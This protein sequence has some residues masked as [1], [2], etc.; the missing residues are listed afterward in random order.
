VIK[1][2]HYSKLAV[3][4][5]ISLTHLRNFNWRFI[6]LFAREVGDKSS[7][8]EKLSA[9][10]KCGLMSRYPEGINNILPSPS[11]TAILL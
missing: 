11:N 6:Y 1:S 9:V 10:M 2:F 5:Y 7:E 3:G 8:K 4:K